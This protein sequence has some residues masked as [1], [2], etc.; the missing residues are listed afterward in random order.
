M[1]NILFFLITT[2][3]VSLSSAVGPEVYAREFFTKNTKPMTKVA[4]CRAF[5]E[6]SVEE[7]SSIRDNAQRFLG[8][9]KKGT[10]KIRYSLVPTSRR[11]YFLVNK[12]VS[13]CIVHC[14]KC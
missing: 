6:R 7:Y 5:G 14:L 2:C 3:L 4:I 10:D 11:Q 8:M 13:T 1:M 9:L 12:S